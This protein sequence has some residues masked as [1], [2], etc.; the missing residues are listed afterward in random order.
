MNHD[1]SHMFPSPEY[2][3]LVSH[4]YRFPG[5]GRGSLTLTMIIDRV[6][7]SLWFS[8]PSFDYCFDSVLLLRLF[9]ARR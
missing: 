6:V 7:V 8:G 5:S 9:R 4:S 2:D 3:R 1:S